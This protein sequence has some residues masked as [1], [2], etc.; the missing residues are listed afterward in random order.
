MAFHV[1]AV[2]GKDLNEN[3]LPNNEPLKSKSQ[4]NNRRFPEAG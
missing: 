3:K 2:E 1:P 4:K